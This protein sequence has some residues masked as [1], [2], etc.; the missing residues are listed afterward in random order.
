VRDIQQLPDLDGKKVLV[1]IDTDVDIEHGHVIDDSRLRAAIPTIKLLLK[2]GATVTLIGHLGRPKGEVSNDFTLKPV[3]SHMA[4]LLV[5]HAHPK[6]LHTEAESPV[7]KTQYKLAKQ[8]TLYENLRFDLGEE[9]DDPIFAAQLADGH[10]YYVNESFAAVHRAAASTVG[11]TK[12]LPA[13]AGLR[14]VDELAHLNLI[15]DNPVR[16][17]ALIVGGAKIEEKLGLLEYL[18]PKVNFV[19]TGGVPANIFLKAKGVDIKKSK[20]EA[21]MDEM[22]KQLLQGQY[23]DKIVLPTD[24]V[25][26]NGMIV[27]VGPR[28]AAAYSSI[29]EESATIFWAGTLGMVEKAEF[30]QGSRRIAEAMAHHGGTR[31]VGGG[32][33]ASALKRFTLENKMSFVSTG[34]GA[35]LEYLAGNNLP[36]L[37]ALA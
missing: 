18:I 13:Y 34:G 31:I 20:Q 1:R 2:K 36:G 4:H 9:K 5:P 23:A 17:F 6:T 12:L 32:D 21:G 3:A 25:W 19:L 26:D 37:T 16:P 10:D 15:K 14:L 27:D 35:A 28:T 22:A 33:T 8:I 30:A 11:I 29:I 7:V 24:Y